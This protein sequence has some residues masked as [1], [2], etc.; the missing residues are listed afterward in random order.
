MIATRVW[1]W[2]L[3]ILVAG[4]LPVLLITW[5]WNA[6]ADSENPYFPPLSLIW[7]Q[8]KVNWVFANVPIHLLPSLEN[9]FVG[10]AIAVVLGIVIGTLVG[11]SPAATR[12][13]EPII[14]FFRAI[15]AVALV[16][17]FILLLGL[18][19]TMRMASIAF[20]AMFPVLIA[21]IEG[22]RST[23]VVLLD[24]ADVFRLTRS[25]I[26]WRVRLPSAMPIVFAGLQV[27]FQIAFIVTIASEYLGSGF[28]LGAFTLIAVD[29]FLI[30]D[31]WTGVILLGFLGYALSVVFDLVERFSLRWYYGQKKLA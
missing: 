26:L 7:G 11:S 19:S 8:F 13:V 4:W 6:S 27:S 15:P 22:I 5:W 23:N 30:L 25:Q 18:D 3:A 14:D 31:A 10:F 28:G 16:P 29:S 21:T 17:I 9:L 24:T 12:Y 20:A 2:I 1:R